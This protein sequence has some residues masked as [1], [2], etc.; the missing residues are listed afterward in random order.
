M[1]N[2][3][4]V[5]SRFYFMLGLFLA[6]IEPELLYKCCV[7]GRLGLSARSL[8]IQI[9][10][11]HT[12]S[13]NIKVFLSIKYYANGWLRNNLQNVFLHVPRVPGG[14]RRIV[15]VRTSV[16]VVV[17]ILNCRTRDQRCGRYKQ[18]RDD[19]ERA[20]TAGRTCKKWKEKKLLVVAYYYGL[21]R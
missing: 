10:Y 4:L 6:I 15:A 21:N 14:R 12:Y 1:K 11:T 16:A 17:G 2:L 9:L 18:Q 3:V 7:D 8:C 5:Y 13:S 20:W 19:F